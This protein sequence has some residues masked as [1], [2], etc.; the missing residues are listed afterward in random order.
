VP[1][2]FHS[3]GKA[4]SL[5]GDGSLSTDAPSGE[6]ADEYRYDPNDPVTT[7]WNLREGPIDDR[8]A[9]IRD[10]ILCYTSQPLGEPLDVVGWVTCRLW[11]SSSAR[12]TDWHVR[13]VDVE[14]DG[15]ARFLCRGA[16][17]ARFRESFEHPKLLEPYEPTLFELT[18]DAIGIRFLPEHR[19]RVEVTSSWFSQ[20]DRNLN[21]GAENFFADDTI[22]VAEQRVHHETGRE[23]CVILP[24]IPPG[25]ATR[26]G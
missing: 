14:P 5:K 25:R 7:V 13:L 12:D 10:D 6:P 3:A 17:R 2:Y 15:M 11:A 16:L 18:M 8:I 21:S 9:T 22:V 19:I 1:F 4:N 24:V 20:Y 26:K 23:S